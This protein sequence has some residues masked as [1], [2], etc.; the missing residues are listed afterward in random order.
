MRTRR[1]TV[2]PI[3]LSRFSKQGDVPLRL[4]PWIP[5]SGL[6][7]GRV[8]RDDRD[9]HSAGASN[10][11]QATALR[12]APYFGTAE[13]FWMAPQASYDLEEARNKRRSEGSGPFVFVVLA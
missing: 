9:M 10:P 11:E 7:R 4:R 8:L 1:I 5:A 12:L 3:R 2:P 6:R 13:Q